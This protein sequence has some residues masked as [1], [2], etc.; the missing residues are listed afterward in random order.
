MAQTAPQRRTPSPGDRLGR[1][2]LVRA[3]GQGAFGSVFEVRDESGQVAALKCLPEAPGEE[4]RALG[5]ITHPGVVSLIDY[6]GPDP[7]WMVMTLASGAPLSDALG[8]RTADEL[9]RIGAALCAALTAVHSAEVCHGDLKPENIVLDPQ[10]GAVK[11]VDFG[12]AGARSGGT[13]QFA[14][15]EVLAGGP[16]T[17]AADCYGLGMTLTA[18]ATGER[19]AAD[20]QSLWQRTQA[21]VAADVQPAWLAE[22]L[23]AWTHPLPEQRPSA[24]EAADVFAAQGF[25]VAPPG[26]GGIRRKA[27][28]VF[29]TPSGLGPV[30]DGFVDGGPSLCLCGPSGSGRTAV[31]RHLARELGARG[32]TI[33]WVRPGDQL[34]ELRGWTQS[35]RLWLLADDFH[36]MEADLQADLWRLESRSGVHLATTS[37]DAG[38]AGM[39]VVPLPSLTEEE[40]AAVCQRLLGAA[41]DPLISTVWGES[42]GRPGSVLDA[43]IGAVRGRGLTWCRGS[44]VVDQVRLAALRQDGQLGQPAMDGLDP[45]TVQVGALLAA[46]RRPL[47]ANAAAEICGVPPAQWSC[48][49][50]ELEA[51]DWV[52]VSANGAAQMSSVGRA[53]A[54]LDACPQAEELH[55][56]LA[57]HWSGPVAPVLGWYLVGANDRRE[58]LRQ[59]PACLA[60]AT[61]EERARLARSLW[62]LSPE[63]S[64]ALP[65][66]TALTAR[67]HVDEAMD[68]VAQMVGRIDDA[69]D[70][71]RLELQLALLHTRRSDWHQATVHLGAAE[72]T[73]GATTEVIDAAARVHFRAGMFGPAL[74]ASMKLAGGAPP[75]D[76]DG[77]ALWLHH[78]AIWAQ[79]AH[80]VEGIEAALAVLAGVRPGA[81]AHLSAGALLDGVRGRLLWHAGD[82]RGAAAAFSRATSG[83][84]R[85]GAV[86][87]ARL[88]NNAGLAYYQMGLL[89]QA[90]DN[91]EQARLGFVRAEQPAETARVLTNLCQGLREAGRWER[92]LQAGRRAVE[93]AAAL[94]LHDIQAAALGNLG[95]AALAGGDPDE[96][97]AHYEAAITLSQTHRLTDGLAEHHRR[98]AALA[99]HRRDPDAL[100]V[101]LGAL[102]IAEDQQDR[103]ESQRCQVLVLLARIRAHHTVDAAEAVQVL[104]REV[105]DGGQAALLAWLRRWGAECLLESGQADSAA[106]MAQGCIRWAR[107]APDHDLIRQAQAVLDDAN[108]LN[109]DRTA[110]PLRQLIHTFVA[111]AHTRT[112]VELARRATE[113]I[114]EVIGVERA[115]VLL[116]SEDGELEEVGRATPASG[117]QDAP[118]ASVLDR[119]V[120]RQREVLATDLDERGE[121]RIATSVLAM[122]LRA[123][124]GLPLLDG[125]RLVGVLYV[126]SSF[127]VDGPLQGATELLRWLADFMAGLLAR[128]P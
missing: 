29:V 34:D 127:A 71:A 89:S 86:D 44:W 21:P 120:A 68:V 91:W 20:A 45:A 110:L 6:G 92:A 62:A 8:T 4:L 113:D 19:P 83:Q 77:L 75:D 48:A 105:T 43:V 82:L 2:A 1:W 100:V 93:Q 104:E 101:A 118:S 119:V 109:T 73:L 81:G 24:A 126:D 108:A 80:Q 67:D 95:D 124:M 85:L 64:L 114:V 84:A 96:A 16:P 70:E 59:G 116:V 28:T 56:Q 26:P 27:S 52:E 125:D 66:V 15:P 38:H 94:R 3:L 111:L 10:T 57:A 14:A 35:G 17:T 32:E 122:D 72:A 112:R 7:Y 60:A 123:A 74:T 30:L 76:D 39:Q 51:L 54:L 103:A 41:P 58:A 97:A 9:C 42:A 37:D 128:L 61:G 40:V 23:K 25:E 107:E 12:L 115:F 47:D 33:R 50:D 121:L 63:P 90:I 46:A 11:L 98:R 117:P 31:L 79:S 5:G 69:A 99:A 53:A 102:G 55:R 88:C 18:L 36:N 106:E 22:L 65:V 49:L 13:P 87:H 78:R